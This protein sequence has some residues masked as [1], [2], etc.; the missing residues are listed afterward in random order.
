MSGFDKSRA[1]SVLESIKDPRT[2]RS[3][4]QMGWVSSVHVHE[5]QVGVVLEVPASLAQG[6][7]PLRAQAEAE[8]AKQPGVESAQ[9]VLTAERPEQ[10]AA[11][12]AP[13]QAAQQGQA[14][15][16][17][18]PSGLDQVKAIVAIASGKGGVGKSTTTVNLALALAERGLRVGVVDADIYGPSV[19]MLLGLEGK[20]KIVAVQGQDRF[21][22]K[23]AHGITANSIGFLIDQDTAM[24]WR[25][26]MVQSALMQLLKA[27]NWGEL[28]LLLIDMPP[29]TGDI[30]LSLAQQA[31]LAGAVIVSTPQDLA[32]IDAKKAMTLF[33]KTNIPV[34]GL[35]ENMSGYICPSCGD[36]SYPFGQGGAGAEAASRGLPLLG[37]VPLTMQV[38]E[39]SDQG[40]PV[41]VEAPASP[42]A[43]AYRDIADAFVTGM[44]SIEQKPAP[45]LVM[46]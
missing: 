2:G 37:A 13:S 31:T 34:V 25:G 30:Q 12:A 32:L 4:V 36:L 23:A 43:Q 3:I 39:G 1:E 38:R 18:G 14:Q 7:A 41:M 42:A 15:A 33:E 45:R 19:P 9:V 17:S 35:I 44:G 10:K 24:A 22:P 29:G 11:A 5:G 28:D 6:A 8:L 40:R 26:P 27:T 21:V 46:D 20:P 16:N